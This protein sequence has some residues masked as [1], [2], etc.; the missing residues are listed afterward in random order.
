MTEKF[1][2][3]ASSTEGKPGHI[4]YRMIERRHRWVCKC[5][6]RTRDEKRA[7]KHVHKEN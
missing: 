6:F 1:D 3:H 7:A 5:G 4:L 2:P